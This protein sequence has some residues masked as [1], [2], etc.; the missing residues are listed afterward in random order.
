METPDI[1]SGQLLLRQHNLIREVAYAELKANRSTWETAER[2]AA[3]LWL[4]TYEL[5]SDFDP[6]KF[7]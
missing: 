2:Q 7:R 1:Q 4:T 5:P 6:M 3:S